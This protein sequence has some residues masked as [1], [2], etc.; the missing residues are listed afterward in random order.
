MCKINFLTNLTLILVTAIGLVFNTSASE[1][2][3]FNSNLGVTEEFTLDS[4]ANQ[5]DFEKKQAPAL[6]IAKFN[7]SGVEFD[8]LLAQAPVPLVPQVP[9]NFQNIPQTQF[10]PQP[11]PNQ[12]PQGQAFPAANVVGQYPAQAPA[13]PVQTP[14]VIP[15]IGSEKSLYAFYSYRLSYMQSDRVLALLKA[16]GY[17]TVEFSSGRGESINESIFTEFAQP[18]K[19]SYCGK[20]LDAA[21]TSLMQPAWM[22]ERMSVGTD[23]LSGT[24]LHQ[25]TTGAPEQRLLIIYEKKIP[26]N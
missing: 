20:I 25:S 10:A 13:P 22:E 9:Q 23:R 26:S 7:D 2:K 14:Q 19:I 21:K 12:A 15:P 16:L 18:A 11:Y 6:N 24:Y 1:P 4:K 17:S 3:G 8:S 5:I